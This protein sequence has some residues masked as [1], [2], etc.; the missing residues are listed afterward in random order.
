[1]ISIHA[2]TRGAT[3]THNIISFLNCYFNPR[4]YK[5]SDNQFDGFTTLPDISI[6]APTRGAT[7]KTKNNSF[8]ISSFQSTLLQEE[9]HQ[10]QVLFYMHFYISI[11]APTRGATSYS[12]IVTS[13]WFYF[14]PRSYKRSDYK[15]TAAYKIR[16]GFQST[17]LQEERRFATLKILSG[18]NISI[19]APTRGATMFSAY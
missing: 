1:M 18:F 3:F 16:E 13:T 4:S 19:H 17:L 11:H 7:I 10:F 9:R 14:N 6:H 2:P 12:P 8:L 15:D 5:R